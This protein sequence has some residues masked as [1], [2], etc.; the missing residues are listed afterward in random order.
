MKPPGIYP[1]KIPEQILHDPKRNAEVLVYRALEKLGE[2]GCHVFYSC[3]WLDQRPEPVPSADGEADFVIAHPEFGFLAVEVKGGLIARDGNTGQWFRVAG[4]GNRE[5]IKNPVNQA[6]TSKHVLLDHL[7]KGWGTDDFPYIRMKHAVVFPNSDKPSSINAFGASMP[8]SM[9]AF[10]QDMP[11][12]GGFV[13]RFLLSKEGIGK[14]NFG[15]LGDKGIKLLHKLFT[16][17]FELKSSLQSSLDIYDS[18][19][20]QNTEEQQRFLDYTVMQRKA[21]VLGGAGT[22]KTFLALTKARQ[23]AESGLSTLVVYFNSPM[24]KDA[25]RKLKHKNIVIKT[26]HQLC[27]DAARSAGIKLSE[28]SDNKKFS[29]DFPQALST[30]LSKECI[31]LFDAIV[32]DEAQD[33]E[34]SWLE[35]CMFCLKDLDSGKFFVFADDNQNLYSSAK[36]FADILSVDAHALVKNVRNT[37]P[38]FKFSNEFYQGITNSSL[39]FTGPDVEFEISEDDKLGVNVRNYIEK[40]KDVEGIPLQN[41]AVIACRSRGQSKAFDMLNEISVDAELE[42]SDSKITFDSV[43][44]FKG[45]ERQVVII[46]DIEEATDSRELQYV[47]MSRARTLLVIFGS[48]SVIRNLNYLTTH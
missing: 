3:D 14:R 37:K 1:I 27:M 48:E 47:A 6:R 11:D 2:I 21:L 23:F 9:F 39:A 13:I 15:K 33:L 22:G 36:N 19:I 44:R 20:T 45:L 46:V 40:L 34:L 29:E 28:Q 7:K 24:A 30:A 32:V 41:I 25:I 38:I 8:L 43:W 42:P 4:N 35:L 26:F 10:K 17:S 18:R 31:H 16:S 5:K 12:L